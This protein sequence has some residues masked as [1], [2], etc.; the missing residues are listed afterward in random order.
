MILEVLQKRQIESLKAGDSFRLG[1]IRY[2]ISQIKYKEIELR[3]QHLPLTDEVIMKVLQKENKKR[4]EVIE[5]FRG[6]GRQD[7]VDKETNE[8]AIVKEYLTEF[9]PTNSQFAP[10]NA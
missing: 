9:S 3:P 6:A 2:L 4:A 7:L 8:L 1:V 5:Q 10:T